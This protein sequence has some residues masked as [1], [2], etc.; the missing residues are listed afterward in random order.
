VLF[1]F[2]PSLESTRVDL[3]KP[4]F[5]LDVHGVALKDPATWPRT[6][7]GLA[8]LEWNYFKT[9]QVEL[10]VGPELPFE[11]TGGQPLASMGWT[12][13]QRYKKSQLFKSRPSGT[14]LSLTEQQANTLW[15]GVRQVLWPKV[16]AAALTARQRADVS[17]LYFHTI[18]NSTVANSA[19]LTCDG[20]TL[21][22]AREIRT[23]LGAEVMTF[24]E[25]WEE[26]RPRYRLYQPSAAETR[27]LLGEQ[28]SWFQQLS[29]RSSP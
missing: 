22:K 11:I 1:P 7:Q 12:G 13:Y 20:N 8:P 29:T 2:L 28:R 17:E 4:V 3:G 9:R 23:E 18:S 6:M 24:T 27:S 15:N 14:T 21:A 16:D 26:Y 19:F 25:A 5:T 10:C